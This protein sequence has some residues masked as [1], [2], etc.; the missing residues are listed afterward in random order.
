M[1]AGQVQS[2]RKGRG[3][4]AQRLAEEMVK[5]GI[6]WDRSIVANLENGRRA[7][8]SVEEFLALA[9]VLDIAPVHLLVP[10]DDSAP[11]QPVAGVTVDPG[12]VR[13]WVRGLDTIGQVDRRRYF[14]AV[15]AHE[16]G[17]DHT[18]AMTPAL[19]QK[20]LDESRRREAER[21]DDGQR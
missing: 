6:P 3:W 14:S 13:A 9:Y 7:V 1:I 4:S 18:G 8:V 12:Q 17:I 16:F 21:G 19:Q 20:M 10:I 2:L 15:P 5:V 11:L